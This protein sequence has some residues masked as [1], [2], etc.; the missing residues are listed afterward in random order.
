M[1]LGPYTSNR[2]PKIRAHRLRPTS[3][4]L[5]VAASDTRP[6]HKICHYL[7]HFRVMVSKEAYG[8]AIVAAGK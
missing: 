7:W 1:L 4:D 2:T 5:N 3:Y 6:L 8:E